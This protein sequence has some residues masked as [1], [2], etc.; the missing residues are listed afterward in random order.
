MLFRSAV[1]AAQQAAVAEDSWIYPPTVLTHVL[2]GQ[3]AFEEELFGPVWAVTSFDS[4]SE[5]I[6]LANA[7]SFGL[8]ASVW[9]VDE[10][11]INR[12]IGTL[13]TGNVFVNDFVRSDPRL[14]FGGVKRSG[15]GKELGEMGFFEFVNWKTVY[16][17]E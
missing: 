9:S 6:R 16:W 17:K 10:A 8:G 12:L 4:E 11:R 1:I 14:P 7:S 13:E 15:H 2:P 5:A 3:P